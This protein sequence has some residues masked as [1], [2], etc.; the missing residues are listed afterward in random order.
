MENGGLQV[1]GQYKV[2]R[3]GLL[4]FLGKMVRHFF[5]N[6]EQFARLCC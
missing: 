4:P 3:V 6:C 2:G 1:E 5:Q